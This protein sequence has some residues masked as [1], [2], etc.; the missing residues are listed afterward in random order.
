MN[1]SSLN[2]AQWWIHNVQQWNGRDII[3]Y[4]P[5]L[6]IQSDASLQGWGAVCNGTSHWSDQERSLHI[7]ALEG[8]L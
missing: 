4:P 7:D 3:R 2:E 5:D 1:Q 8:I 6:I